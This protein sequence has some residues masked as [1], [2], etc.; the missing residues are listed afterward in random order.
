MEQLKLKD[1]LNY[2]FLSA[3][4]YAPDGKRAVF[5]VSNSNEE[6]NCYES[7]LWMYDGQLR[8]L[9]GIGKEGQFFWEDETHIL[10][11]AVR[12]AAEEKRQKAGEQFTSFYRLDVTGG[13][14]VPAFTFPFAAQDLRSLGNG[15]W[16]VMGK[17]DAGCSEYYGMTAEERT[18]ADEARKKEKDYEVFDEIPFWGNGRGVTN[19]LRRALFV[20]D[21]ADGSCKRVTDS[22]FQTDSFEV[23]GDTVYFFGDA[24]EAHAI[25]NHSLL[26]ALDVP[27]GEVRTIREYTGFYAHELINVNGRLL[28]L[29]TEGRRHGLNENEWVYQVDTETGELTV[30]REEEYSMYSSVGSDCRYG[31]GQEMRANGDILYHLTTREGNSHLYALSMDGNSVPVVVKDGSIDEFDIPE[32]GGKALM[33]A[34]YDT[35]LQ[36]LYEADLKT[37]EVTQV[38]HF[39]DAVLEGKYVAVPQPISVQSEGWTIGGWVLLPKDF[40]PEKSYPAVLDI[41]GGPK[42]VYGPVFYHEMQVW[43]NMGYFVFYCNPMGSDGRDNKFMDIRGHYGETDYKNLMDFT[44]AV[45]AAYPQIDRTKVCETGGSYGGF[46]TNWIIGHTDRFVCAASQRSIANWLSFY[47]VSDIGVEFAKDQCDADPISTPDKMWE[48]SPMRYAGNVKTPTLFIHS[49]EDYRC[50]LAEGLQMYTSLAA[51]GVPTR[52]CL[53]HGENHE[54]SRSGKP[55]HRVRRLTEITNWFEKY[56]RE[57]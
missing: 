33:V 40:D 1:F 45:L 13:E 50:P 31:G 39:N 17:I 12:S 43:A 25:R 20:Y 15:K 55:Q 49:D 37:G 56:A 9:T 5:V 47:G 16:L 14:A 19:K 38:S 22:L 24:F 34:M 32:Q 28:M 8:Q 23:I 54:L 35:R 51:Q 48:H 26:Y 29:G 57:K 36:E 6:E 21:T 3:V 11:P 53:F 41:H 44:D 10:F 27:T 7:R 2:R 4:R 30:I 52:L 18:E 46:M 42:T